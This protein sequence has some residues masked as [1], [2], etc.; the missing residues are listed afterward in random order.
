MCHVQCTWLILP[1]DGTDQRCDRAGYPSYRGKPMPIMCEI[2]LPAS[3]SI[4][5]IPLKW[6]GAGS[7]SCRSDCLSLSG[8]CPGERRFL[9][10]A[11][12]NAGS[13]NA[14]SL[15]SAIHQRV[16]RLEIEVPTALCHVVGVADAISELRSPATD[17]TD[18]CHI[19]TPMPS[20]AGHET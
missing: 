10:S 13:A 7:K 8:G 18:S 14:Y 15:T 4:R 16:N 6:I 19:N 9:Y 11:V 5:P 2:A 17:F 3:R 1:N 20:P 12:A